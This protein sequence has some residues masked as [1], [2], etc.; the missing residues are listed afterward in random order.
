MSPIWLSSYPRSGNTLV[1]TILFHCFN[2]KTGSVYPND[3]GGNSNLENYVGHIEQNQNRSITFSDGALP[4]IKTHE[5]HKGENKTIYIVRDGR[6][7]SASFWEFT[8]PKVPMS[9]IIEGKHKFGKWCDHL[10]S[11]NPLERPNTL[12]LKYEDILENLDSILIKLRDFL[13]RD[14]VS[15]N[16][17]SRNSIAGSDGKWVRKKNGLEECYF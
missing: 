3:L 13:D 17:P 6:A 2:L 10:E 9:N 14:I 8:N 15:F 5:F 11:W 12:L 7:A 4:I 16:L 1:R